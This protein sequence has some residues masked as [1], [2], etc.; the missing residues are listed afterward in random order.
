[1]ADFPIFR[2]RISSARPRHIA[3]LSRIAKQRNN[4]LNIIVGLLLIIAAFAPPIFGTEPQPNILQPMPK[5]TKQVILDPFALPVK[6]TTAQSSTPKTKEQ[7]QPQIIPV[8]GYAMIGNGAVVDG[9]SKLYHVGDIYMQ[10]QILEITSSGMILAN[11][12]IV[13]PS[14]NVPQGSTTNI[15]PPIESPPVPSNNNVSN[16][17]GISVMPTSSD[18]PR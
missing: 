2:Y 3:D 7:N 5:A 11:G 8:Q 14:T 9:S 17:Q 16:Q 6:K 13:A 12:S 15:A 10:Q 4:T 18:S 1:M